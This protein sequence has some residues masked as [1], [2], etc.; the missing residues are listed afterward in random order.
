MTR[1]RNFLVVPLVCLAVMF[2]AVSQAAE[3]VLSVVPE[4]ALGFGVVNRLAETDATIQ[5]VAADMQL[6]VPSLLDQLKEATGIGPGLDKQGSTALV[7]M[8]GEN[9]SRPAVLLYV[10]V[11]D[12]GQ[13]I[14]ALQPGEAEEGLSPVQV[15]REQFLVGQDGGYAVFAEWRHRSALKAAIA[16]PNRLSKELAPL[17]DWLADHSGGLVVTRAGVEFISAMVQK[18]LRQVREHFTEMPPEFRDQMEPAIAVFGVYEQ[19]FVALEKNVQTYAAAVRVDKRGTI[20]IDERTRLVPGGGL[21]KMFGSV[22]KPE[23]DL[24]AGLPKGPFF[25]AVSGAVPEGA[26]DALMDFSGEMMKAMPKLY[27]LDEKETEELMKIS[28]DS[29]KGVRGMAFMIAVGKPDEPVLSSMSSVMKVDDSRAFL[30]EYRKTIDAMNEMMR[31]KKDSIFSGIK[32]KELE[33]EGV[34][35][36]EL[37]MKFPVIEETAQMPGFEEM[38][39]MMVGPGNRVVTYVAA[40]DEQTLVSA[41]GKRALLRCIKAVKDP[42]ARLSSNP[43]LA[44]TAAML[45]P[46][47]QWVGYLSPQGTIDFINRFIASLPMPPHEKIQLPEFAPT[48]PI[49]FAVKTAPGELVSHTVVPKAVLRAIGDFII[50]VKETFG[51]KS[52][53]LDQAPEHTIQGPLSEEIPEEVPVF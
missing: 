5:Q 30:A 38:M 42:E 16:S 51:R 11:T 44:K 12:Y 9:D 22:E 53:D 1:R 43:R 15:M 7:V 45:S 20:H 32:V 26:M 33:V 31:G 18:G 23:G 48:P 39:K 27:G 13:F 28:R 35:A 49:A 19:L 36:L 2:A 21:A 4:G 40:A 24:L 10:P 29:M 6:P 46:E 8:P 41:Y 3:D 47:A 37:R 52:R 14:A 25:F 34:P 50:E 17:Q